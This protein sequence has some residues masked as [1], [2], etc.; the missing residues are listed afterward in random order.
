[1]Y[2]YTYIH[3]TPQIYDNI[4]ANFP[5]FH[6]RIDTGSTGPK[7]KKNLPEGSLS[8]SQPQKGEGWSLSMLLPVPLPL[9]IYISPPCFHLTAVFTQ[10]SMQS[11][12][13]SH[14]FLQ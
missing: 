6:N 4:R 1:M 12:S 10:Q 9:N 11:L 3:Y 7:I 5:R 14:R 13:A 8:C 2:V